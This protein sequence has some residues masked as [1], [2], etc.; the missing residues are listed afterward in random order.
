M[1]NIKE[2][3]YEE[4]LLDFT[5]ILHLFNFVNLFFKEINFNYLNYYY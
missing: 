3:E 2:F 5:I 1:V 4:L